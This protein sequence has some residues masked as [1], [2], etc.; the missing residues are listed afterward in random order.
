MKKCFEDLDTE[1][2]WKCL[3]Q[4]YFHICDKINCPF[5]ER[6]GFCD[7]NKRKIET[8]IEHEAKRTKK[9]QEWKEN[10]SVIWKQEDT[11]SCM[12]VNGNVIWDEKDCDMW[13]VKVEDETLNNNVIDTNQ[14]VTSILNDIKDTLDINDNVKISSSFSL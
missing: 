10:I 13:M 11:D 9:E 6:K 8:N 1:V 3:V 14:V 12:D 2:I 4:Q 7:S 5:V